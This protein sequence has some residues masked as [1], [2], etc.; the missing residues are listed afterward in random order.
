[1]ELSKDLIKKVIKGDRNAQHTLYNTYSAKMYGVCLRYLANPEIA[2]DILHDGFIKVFSSI[3]TF[4]GN[5]SLEG[6]ILRIMVNTALEYIRRS[7]NNFKVDIDEAKTLEAI[8][9]TEGPDYQMLL[10]IIAELPQQYRTVFNLY[11]I[12]E[13][14]HAEIA[15]MLGISESTSK[16]NYSRAKAI[17]RVRL[18]NFLDVNYEE[19]FR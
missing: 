7:K 16:S 12:E 5:G 9:N 8:N 4:R 3:K 10:K 1:M 18:E 13:Y 15:E 14:T 11:A 19:F 6:W 17:L 2:R